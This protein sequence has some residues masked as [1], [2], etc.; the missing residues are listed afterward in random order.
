[1]VAGPGSRALGRTVWG[2]VRAKS[3]ALARWYTRHLRDHA[4]HHLLLGVAVAN[5]VLLT[6]PL[7]VSLEDA[8]ST[9]SHNVSAAVAAL[10]PEFSSLRDVAIVKI[11]KDRFADPSR[12]A[13][14][15]PLDRCELARDLSVLLNLNNRSIRLIAI[16][17]DLSPIER[18]QFGSLPLSVEYQT[19]LDNMGRIETL[20]RIKVAT[21]CQTRL[22][23]LIRENSA[24]LVL[25]YPLSG[26]DQQISSAIDQ[27]YLSMVL[28]NVRFARVDLQATRGLVRNQYRHLEG[29]G[30]DTD[31]LPYFGDLVYQLVNTSPAKQ[32]EQ[33]EQ[34]EPPPRPA[35]ETSIPLHALG[36]FFENGRSLRLDDACFLPRSEPCDFDVIM[37]GAGYSA[38]DEH[39][40]PHGKLHGLDIH[41]ANSACPVTTH[42]QSIHHRRL[43]YLLELVLAVLVLAPVMH[44]FWSKYYLVRS[45]R[46]MDEVWRLQRLRTQS[47]AMQNA[48]AA[49]RALAVAQYQL[50]QP[51]AAYLWLFVLCGV[52]LAIW[53]LFS[54]VSA[55][56]AGMCTVVDIP[57]AFAA[58]LFIDAAV[59]QGVQVASHQ[60][61][62]EFESNRATTPEDSPPKEPAITLARLLFWAPY[63]TLC[64]LAFQKISH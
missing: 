57:A 43:H 54:L 56:S 13:G 18:S 23:T 9:Y 3:L 35:S 49:R 44:F 60:M 63:C 42:S 47:A 15:S 20:D 41:A 59:V 12:Y 64:V 8:A 30:A 22:D 6:K 46:R 38:D 58:G 29:T 27:W 48:P 2:A 11:D 5:V 62:T 24:R 28:A 10:Q 17:L 21:E 31:K 36:G 16:D 45:G 53:V 40:T 34:K 14:T 51:H 50:A 19:R 32:K 1:M 33:K 25:M 55:L 7:W 52:L 37:F 39:D 61:T 4:L 26:S